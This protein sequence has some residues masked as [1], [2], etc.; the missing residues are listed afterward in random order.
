MGVATRFV[1]ERVEAFAPGAFLYSGS[2]CRNAAPTPAVAARRG[3][4]HNS[5]WS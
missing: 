4:G 3:L 5:P 2:Q 1:L